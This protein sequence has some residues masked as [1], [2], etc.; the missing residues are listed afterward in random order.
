VQNGVR[1]EAA[2]AQ[3]DR[4]LLSPGFAASPR[5]CSLLRYLV[6]QTLNGKAGDIKEYSIGLE[7]FGL[8]SSFDPKEKSIVR[9][10]AAKLREKLAE[11]YQGAGQSDPIVVDIPKGAYVPRFLAVPKPAARRV[12]PVAAAAALILLA[13]GV[14]GWRSALPDR[15][16]SVAV[17]DIRNASGNNLD[18]WLST[19]LAEMVTED[20]SAVDGL[21][22]VPAEQ[23]AQWRRDLRAADVR[24]QLA[25]RGA[26]LQDRLGAKYAVLAD[27]RAG[28]AGIPSLEVATR[29][30]RLSDGKIVLEASDS[31]SQAQLYTL[32]AQ[33]AG[34]VT[35]ALGVAH[36]DGT[37]L[38][39]GPDRQSMHWYA[40]GVVKLR[41][42]DPIA[43][44]NFLEKSVMGDPSN[45]LARSTLAETYFALEM[46]ERASV[47]AQA[48]LA[49]APPLPPLERLALE[50]RCQRAM[51]DLPSA[52]RSYERL[53]SK[54]PESIDYGLNLAELQ[55]KSGL[56]SQA[57]QTILELRRQRPSLADEARIDYL[58]ALVQGMSG[59]IQKGLV[60]IGRC[61]NKAKRLGARYLYARARLREGG[62]LMNQMAPGRLEA[63]D[64]A[65]AMCRKGGY[66]DCQM[67]ALRVEGN[68]FATRDAGRALELYGQ[69]A[70]IARQLGSRAGLVHLLRGMAFVASHQLLDQEAE[71]RYREAIAAIRDA[72]GDVDSVAGD[73]AELLLSE[74]RVDEADRILRAMPDSFAH[75]LTW[76]LCTAQ[77]E[78][79]SGENRPA[80]RRIESE[81]AAARKS[82][83][84]GDLIRVLGEAFFLHTQQGDLRQAAADLRDLEISRPPEKWRP[85]ATLIP[86]LRAE[87][88]LSR[89]DWNDA[90][91]Q[92]A[93]AQIQFQA[94]AD[95]SGNA[96][97]AIVRA[98]AL[99]G[100]GRAAEAL[101]VLDEIAPALDHSR[102]APLQIRARACRFRAHALMSV[103]PNGAEID[104]L[105]VAA[106]DLRLPAL[107]REVNAAARQIRTRCSLAASVL[108][109]KAGR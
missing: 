15:H 44:R 86:Y 6:E 66:R 52:I 49:L 58:E 56:G 108:P 37:G 69:G 68:F 81:L 77:Q 33:M 62:L 36:A 75:N 76:N 20:L 5:L 90:A 7:V 71:K 30:Q 109:E 4:I 48:A 96:T 21:R 51:D 47:E 11:Y 87:L 39:S 64:D 23:V 8:P 88:G 27:F 34:R 40:E 18:G 98:E 41:E 72:G 107:S 29:V 26:E 89:G 43:A 101:G 104:A 12:W 25:R 59:E 106:Q 13:L 105:V 61:E 19:A 14:L 63:L 35:R 17:V 103:C 60:A 83:G 57:L 45:F 38:R 80:A 99:V 46:Q 1:H 85:S 24:A 65:L 16:P 74:G 92:A 100:A 2:R 94:D 28:G 3:V 55:D 78:R 67:N 84:P 70:E 97:A 42:F 10:T 53:W 91:A 95:L 54:S 93:A 82:D 31:G 79:C 32:A 102:R 50:A 9:S 73:L 22:T